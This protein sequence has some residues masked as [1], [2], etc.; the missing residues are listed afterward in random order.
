M[1][2]KTVVSSVKFMMFN[3]SDD[4]LKSLKYNK[5]N[6]EPKFDPLRIPESTTLEVESIPLTETCCL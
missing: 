4:L 1:G 2:K 3:A 6:N 5:N